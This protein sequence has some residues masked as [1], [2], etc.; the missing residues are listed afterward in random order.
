MFVD[1]E[2][3]GILGS[4]LSVYAKERPNIPVAKKKKKRNYHSWKRRGIN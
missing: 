3:N 4:S 1:V 2:I